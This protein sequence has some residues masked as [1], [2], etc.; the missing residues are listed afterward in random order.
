MTPISEAKWKVKVLHS[1][2]GFFYVD[3]YT[4]ADIGLFSAMLQLQNKYHRQK[5]SAL[6]Y[7]K[8]FAKVNKL[9]KWEVINE[10]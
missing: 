6:N 8:Q 3:A 4:D 5:S 1:Y 10:K 7:W 2:L 9:T